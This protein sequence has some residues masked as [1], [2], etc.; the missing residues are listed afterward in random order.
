M[1]VYG[2][3]T[4]DLF[5][6]TLHEVVT[7]YLY[8]G[9]YLMNMIEIGVVISWLHSASDILIMLSKVLSQTKYAT[10]TAI[11]FLIEMVIWFYMRLI[12]FPYI[13]WIPSTYDLN[14]G[15]WMIMPFFGYGLY[16]LVL[17]H[18]YWFFLFCQIFLHFARV[19]EAEDKIE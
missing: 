9:C 16:C 12:V 11:V 3:K 18:A 15:H 7:I 14:Q 13:A 8:A 2:E 4:K 1:Y 19:G 17:L 6:M 10:A 5:E